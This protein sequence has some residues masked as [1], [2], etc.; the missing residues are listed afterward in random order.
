[1]NG[2]VGCAESPDGGHN[3]R[4]RS[5]PAAYFDGSMGRSHR[6]RLVLERLRYALV[7]RTDRS[8]WT[9]NTAIPYCSHMVIRSRCRRSDH[10]E[11]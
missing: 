3:E 8:R 1:M 9:T 5:T 10:E 2:G 4:C 7:T 11:R 6:S